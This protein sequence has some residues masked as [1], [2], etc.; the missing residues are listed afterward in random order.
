MKDSF[1]V[2]KYAGTSATISSEFLPLGTTEEQAVAL[3]QDY[4]SDLWKGFISLQEVKEINVPK[5]VPS[6]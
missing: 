5:R 6:V 4:K 2:I 1:Y 3:A